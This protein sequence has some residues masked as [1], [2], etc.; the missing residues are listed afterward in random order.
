MRR[1]RLILL[2][3]ALASSSMACAPKRVGPT[4]SGYFFTVLVLNRNIFLPETTELA[5]NVQNAQGQPVDGVPVTFQVEPG[6]AQDALIVPPQALTQGGTARAIFRA[7]TTG[8]ARVMVRVDNEVQAATI[9]I[10]PR[11]SPP[12]SRNAPATGHWHLLSDTQALC[13]TPH[14]CLGTQISH[15]E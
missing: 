6:W 11:P 3:L 8:A 15:K 12:N 2:C 4:A 1:L 9:I 13:P 7:R 5:V 10:S 14:T